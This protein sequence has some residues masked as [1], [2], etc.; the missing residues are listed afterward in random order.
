MLP[1]AFCRRFMSSLDVPVE[2]WEVM[3][4]AATQTARRDDLW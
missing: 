4:D 3:T 1:K 2:G